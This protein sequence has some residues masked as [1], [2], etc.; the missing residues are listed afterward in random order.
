MREVATLIRRELELDSPPALFAYLGPEAIAALA[1]HALID[2]DCVTLP[3]DLPIVY[4]LKNMRDSRLPVYFRTFEISTE[5]LFQLRTRRF[6]QMGYDIRRIHDSTVLIGGVGLI[7][8]EVAIN[9][10]VLG[11]G[12][13]IAVDN[14]FVDWFNVYRQTAFSRTDVYLAKVDALK[15]RLVDFGN[16][17][18]EAMLFDVPSWRSTDSRDELVRRIGVLDEAIARSDLI[19]GAFD[20]F[21]PRALLQSLCLIRKRPFLATALEPEVGQVMLYEK[22]E[23]GCYC[24]GLPNPQDGRWVEGGACTLAS[25][26]SQR[27]VGAIATKVAIEKVTGQK[28]HANEFR[29]NHRTSE[30]GTATHRASRLCSL[31]GPAGAV[32]SQIGDAKPLRKIAEWLFTDSR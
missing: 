8:S 1:E 32:R 15:R 18:V 12:N 21:S 25:L 24:C 29:Y 13:I 6:S 17:K 14:G 22:P 23:D 7:G 27:I 30:I 3:E 26:D 10:A 11:I 31:C 4:V 28:I 9:L 5:K 16:I 20:S 19:V 2:G